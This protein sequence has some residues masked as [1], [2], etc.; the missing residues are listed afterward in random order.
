MA[1]TKIYSTKQSAI[2]ILKAVND[3]I[4]VN[5]DGREASLAKT[6]LEEA[7]MWLEKAEDKNP[8]VVD[9]S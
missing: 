4:N 6:K 7:I 1:K 3:L 5:F 9:A 2:D 8:F